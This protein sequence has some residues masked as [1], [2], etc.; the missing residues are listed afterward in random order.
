MSKESNF[1]L[2]QKMDMFQMILIIKLVR[3]RL[4]KVSFIIIRFGCPK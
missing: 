4:F 2:L 1:L 3:N